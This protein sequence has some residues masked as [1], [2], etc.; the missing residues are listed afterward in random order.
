[1]STDGTDAFAARLALRLDR[2]AAGGTSPEHGPEPD[3]D[4]DADADAL[5]AELR[6]PATWSDPPAGL[7]AAVLAAATAAGTG[8]DEEA[9][10]PL[11]PRARPWRLGWMVAAAAA[12]TVFFT[13]GVL[14]AERAL[15][16]RGETYA[17]GATDLA[18]GATATVAVLATG[19]GFKVELA[20]EQLPAAAPGSYYAAWLRGPAGIV[21]LGSFH[22]REAGTTIALWSGVDPADHPDLEVTLQSADDPPGPSARVVLRGRLTR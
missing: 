11:H 13:V 18:P 6:D 10:V 14:A 7:R 17:V 19:S 8:A 9:P 2:S 12:V 21:P 15:Q 20:P 3:E 5:V 22:G 4:A 1:M 16:P